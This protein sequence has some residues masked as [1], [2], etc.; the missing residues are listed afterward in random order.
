[1]LY[2]LV[3]AFLSRSKHLLISW[4]QSPSAVI[5][6]TVQ[7]S[8]SVMSDSLR[9]QE[10]QHARPPCPS[11]SPGVHSDSHP[12]S[13]WCH[14][15]IS[16]SVVPFSSH[17]QSFPAIR[18]ICSESVLH[19]RWPKHWRFSFSISPSNKYSGLIYFRIYWL[20]L[21]AV[22][23]QKH[24]LFCIQLSLYSNSHIHT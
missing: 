6:S 15:T 17:L 12:S 22:Q 11:S 2:R 21:L 19:I 4:L 16:S 9:S 8:H 20:D 3:I 7:F 14:P 23:V 1:M 5:F 18:V 10:S 13:Q 24:Q